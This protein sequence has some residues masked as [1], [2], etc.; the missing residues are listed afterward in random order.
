M[1]TSDYILSKLLT[2]FGK[3]DHSY[4]Y[5][6]NV[7][8]TVICIFMLQSTENYLSNLQTHFEHGETKNDIKAIT[9][10]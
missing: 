2:I 4:E 1:I 6:K 3:T 10:N 9:V 5:M 7:Y 8:E